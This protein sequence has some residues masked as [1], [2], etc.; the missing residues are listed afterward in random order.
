MSTIL[1]LLIEDSYEPRRVASTNGGEYVSPC[2]GC[3]GKDRFRVWPEQKG[4]RWWCRGCGK[5]GDAIQY[6]RDFRGLNY[7]QALDV[8]GLEPI[9]SVWSTSV[10]EPK[11]WEP[12]ESSRPA[13]LWL[14][15]AKALVGWAEARLW[16]QEGAEVLTWLH[17]ARGLRD[18]AIRG[19]RLGWLPRD[20]WRE[21]QVWGLPE[22]LREDGKPK[23]LWLPSGLVIPAFQ[24]GELVRVR[25]RRPEG[26]PR[27]YCLPGSSMTPMVTASAGPVV[28]VESELDALLLHQEVG[29]LCSVLALGSAQVRPD[30]VAHASLS[31]AGKI[32]VALDSDQAGAEQAW[33]WWLTHYTQAKRWPII[34]GK[35]PCEAWKAGL[36]LQAWVRVG[37]MDTPTVDEAQQSPVDEAPQPQPQPPVGEAQQ[38]SARPPKRQRC[39]SSKD[40]Y[41][42]ED[43]PAEPIDTFIAGLR[44]RSAVKKIISEFSLPIRVS[45]TNE[46]E[47]RRQLRALYERGVFD[48]S[49]PPPFYGNT[50]DIDENALEANA[51]DIDLDW[52]FDL[53]ELRVEASEL[54]AMLAE[55]TDDKVA[56]WK[57]AGK[58]NLICTECRAELVGRCYSHF[59]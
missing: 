19:A 28:V 39:K 52:G 7:Y 32:L 57:Q 30:K 6:L 34:Q 49:K 38:P 56:A 10:K 2:P 58:C 44:D 50:E 31:Q 48:P 29:A 14:T 9:F 17:E 40:Q 37:L 5:K 46:G 41:I 27:Y 16:G 51:D 59:F 18:E 24:E 4:G 3:G 53:D 21:R 11:A 22:V 42:S 55:S 45:G 23:K 36:D 20:L 1:D 25:I 8:L 33:K 13:D 15:K 47:L 54:Q 43:K 35:D 26:E 12:K